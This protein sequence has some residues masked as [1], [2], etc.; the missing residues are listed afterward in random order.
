MSAARVLVYLLFWVVCLP[1][2]ASALDR[3]PLLSFADALLAEQ[4]YYRA[5]TEYK[6]FL[7]L[8]P[9]APEA[10]EAALGIAE[11]YLAGERWE[12]A[13]TAFARVIRDYPAAPQ[14]GT[15]RYRS[16]ELHWRK[17]EYRLAREGWRTL[18]EETD[19]PEVGAALRYR[20]AWSL[21][22][23]G[24]YGLAR[25]QLQQLNAAPA[26][27]LATELERMQ[28]LP[29]KSPGVAGTLSALLPGAGQLYVERPRDAALAF[30][31]N[32]AFL[33]G[34]LESFA[35]GNETVG[36]L[37]LFFEAG[38]YT[39]NIFNAVNHAHKYNRD[40][41]EREKQPLRERYGVTLGRG[42]QGPLFGMRYR[43]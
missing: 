9:D 11:A 37:L 6:R 26:A 17:G 10:P 5:I 22:E 13:E 29:S 23:E 33:L 40:L 15:A 43:F 41:H 31:L 42:D 35:S 24:R 38:W 16:I 25:D 12:K 28:R 14:A 39:G 19:Q 18:L 2:P 1:A 20:I 8:S 3:H 27:G 36:A 32:A 7:H 34:A 21:I 30:G 4:D